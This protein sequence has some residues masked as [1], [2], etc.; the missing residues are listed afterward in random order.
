L[1]ALL[2]RTPALLQGDWQ[3]HRVVGS[4]ADELLQ[5]TNAARQIPAILNNGATHPEELTLR[6]AAITCLPGV[7]AT[8]GV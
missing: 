3:G 1:L 5:N 8:P 7:D 2:V 4:I 6:L